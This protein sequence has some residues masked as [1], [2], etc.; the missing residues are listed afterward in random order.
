MWQRMR[1][2]HGIERDN[3]QT[4]Q[5]SVARSPPHRAAKWPF[6][7]ADG[8]ARLPYRR[9]QYFRRTCLA[10]CPTTWSGALVSFPTLD[11]TPWTIPTD[12]WHWDTD[13]ATQLDGPQSLFTFAV[14]SHIEPQGG[15]TLLLAGSHHLLLHFFAALPPAERAKP[16]KKHRAP[17]LRSSPYLASLTG[18]APCGSGSHRLLYGAGGG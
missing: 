14:F 11:N 9:R 4:W 3:P 8:D 7:G 1:S 13:V 6:P 16:R 10:T 15:G 12:G 2:V 18:N 5:V 17:F